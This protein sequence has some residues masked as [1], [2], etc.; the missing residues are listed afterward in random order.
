MKC[1]GNF[2]KAH[3]WPFTHRLH[4]Q[5]HLVLYRRADQV[6]HNVSNFSL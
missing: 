2:S 6:E 1:V 5:L 3:K 4:R